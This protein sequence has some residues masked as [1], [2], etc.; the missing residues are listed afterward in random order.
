MNVKKIVDLASPF[1]HDTP[2]WPTSRHQDRALP[3]PRQVGRVH[4]WLWHPPIT[5]TR[6]PHPP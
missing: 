6:L 3:L 4:Q 1:G 5:R 2:L